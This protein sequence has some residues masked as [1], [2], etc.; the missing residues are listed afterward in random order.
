MFLSFYRFAIVFYVFVF[1]ASLSVISPVNAE[2]KNPIEIKEWTVPYDGRPRDPFAFGSDKVWFVDQVNGYLANLTPSTGQFFKRELGDDAGPHNLIVG[3]DG[4]VWFA[5]NLNGYI[6]RYDPKT[7]K[8]ERIEMPDPEAGDPHTLVFDAEQ[9]HIWFTV[10]HGNFIGRLRLSDRSVELIKVPTKNARPYGIKVAAN[11]TPWV[12]LLG[13][14]KLASLDPSTLALTEY[15]IPAD[16]ARPRRLEITTDGRIWYADYARGKLGGYDP[17]SKK[18][19]EWSLLSGD[20]S[21]PYGMAVDA[22]DIVWVVETGI[23]PNQ[24]VGF[25]TQAEKIVSN[26]PIPSGGGTIRHMMFDP[27]TG[28]VWFGAD[29]LTIGRANVSK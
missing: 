28:Y 13:T 22:N 8:I 19:K 6:G 23:E 15:V 2:N 3:N 5:G 10:Q 29:S 20:R 17:K 27:S 4:M 24:F 14:N 16:K 9:K 26:T 11:G 25:D 21:A 18:F 12:V 1:V 7:D